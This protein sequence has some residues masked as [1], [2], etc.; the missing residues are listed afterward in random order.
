MPKRS[1]VLAKLHARFV[2]RRSKDA[3][4]HCREMDR[5][6]ARQIERMAQQGIITVGDL[7]DALPRLSRSRQQMSI[8]LISVLKIQQ[9][10]PVLF[11]LLAVR[12]LRWE[13][14]HTLGGLTDRPKV[15]EKFLEIGD[16][17]LRSPTPDRHWL[18]AVILG[19]Q[20]FENPRAGELL[21]EIF[22]RTDLPGWLRGDAGDK[23]GLC[24][25][26]CD[27]R[28]KLFRRCRDA[29]I[30]GLT[31][32]D[33]DVQFWSMYV[34]WQLADDYKLRRVQ[35]L[36][37]LEAAL[38]DLRRIAATDHRLAPGYWW[39]MSGEAEDVIHVLETGHSPEVTADE[40]WTDTSKR[41][42]WNRE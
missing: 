18:E 15:I 26:V 1:D 42:V 4:K 10:I 21:V 3:P 2:A 14:A 34:I 25:V 39:P 6:H 36:N 19:L 30:R 9:A 27:R 40:R 11:D 5:R 35:T 41:G 13:C 23:L 7:I 16:S 17:E 31:E 20:Y 8:W 28:T 38:P 22:E 37:G 24:A 33:I 32:D 12:S 29:A